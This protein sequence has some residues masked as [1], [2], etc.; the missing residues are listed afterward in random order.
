[1]PIRNLCERKNLELL[2]PA[3]QMECL[4]AVVEAG[5]DAVYLGGKSFNMR[6]LRSSLNFSNDD[7]IAARQ[8]TSEKGV[9][10]YVTVNNLY[11][12][13]SLKQ[14]G[15][16]LLFLQDTGVD[17]LI[18]QDMA[19]VNLHQKLG[20]NLP[21]H[22]SVQMG[23]NN[24][25]SVLYLEKL[26]FERVILSKNLSLEEIQHIYNHSS[27]GIEYFVH[28]DLC[29]SH[30]GQCYMSSFVFGE[31]GNKGRCRKPC[32]W[33]FQLAAR[34]HDRVMAGTA[35]G[36]PPGYHLAHNDMCLFDH[37]EELVN[38]GVS[39]FKIEGR[40]REASVV[41]FLVST[42]RRGLDRLINGP[43]N[44]AGSDQEDLRC[45]EER[46]IRNFTLGSLCGDP[47]A[48]SVGMDGSRE[49]VFFS[50]APEIGVLTG[51]ESQPVNLD[52]GVC[53]ALQVKTRSL[54]ALECAIQAGASQLIVDSGPVFEDM[55]AWNEEKII[56]AI[57]VC[58]RSGTELLLEMPR[59]GHRYSFSLLEKIEKRLLPLGLKHVI[60]HDPGMIR[61]MQ[62]WGIN[63]HGGFGLNIAN[64]G[65][66]EFWQRQGLY[67]MDLS[68]EI[69]LAEIDFA[70][71]FNCGLAVHGP[72]CGL[73]TD[74]NVG[75]GEMAAE[76]GEELGLV[77]EQGQFYRL[78][79]D[80]Q[81]RHHIY[82][83]Y[84]LCLFPWLPRVADAGIK[85]VRINGEF[86]SDALL[87]AT[88]KTYKQALDEL[89][90]GEWKP[91]E[92][93]HQ[94]LNKSPGPLSAMAF[95]SPGDE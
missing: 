77:D 71:G 29:V 90:R 93:F 34:G 44:V 7:L 73:I 58:R 86:Y 19:V 1:M 40:M 83:P 64:S 56:E 15:D 36:E 66:A 16:Y 33:P 89:A 21:L 32:R 63:L 12:D 23:I 55:P 75:E 38:S 47:A 28:G 2:A 8:Y 68:Q 48:D 80:F 14:L 18:V 27:I 22:A 60:V 81:R 49:P 67:A 69:K 50:R 30:T 41:G 92:A 74:V 94:L 35:S 26:G 51:E 82:Y 42:Y 53:M 9:K 45:L 46:R 91:Q 78:L 57:D 59:L 76:K 37:L 13:N 70:S 10:M 88:T 5:C 62:G 39:S 95:T 11:T 85:Y 4:T 24:L 72:L 54:S 65:A 43:E 20:M 61:A 6:M 87:S 52:R 84:D 31:S 25:D 17:A 79:R 3:G